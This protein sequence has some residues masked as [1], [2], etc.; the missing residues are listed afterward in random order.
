MIV[1]YATMLRSTRAEYVIFHERNLFRDVMTSCVSRHNQWQGD[2]RVNNV[3][4]CVY[5]LS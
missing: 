3:D 1:S 2:R 5:S 4:N